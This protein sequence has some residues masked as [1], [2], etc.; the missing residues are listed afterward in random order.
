MLDLLEL[1]SFKDSVKKGVIDRFSEDEY[2]FVGYQERNECFAISYSEEM[3]LL[4]HRIEEGLPL[5]M[6]RGENW[7]LLLERRTLHIKKSDILSSYI[8]A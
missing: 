2:G 5:Y 3:D 7:H 8:L 4:M 6:I 1:V